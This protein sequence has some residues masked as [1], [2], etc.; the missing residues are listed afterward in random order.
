MG[1]IKNIWKSMSTKGVHLPFV[2][3]PVSGK[4]SIT[5]LFPYVTFVLSVISI[6]AL[7]FKPSL[8]IAT[9][10]TLIFWG[11]SVVFYMLRKISKATFDVSDGSFE[12]ESGAKSDR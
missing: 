6:I 5:L 12:L 2:H 4:P 1:K 9:T 7:H 10:T 8:V 3:D 11:V